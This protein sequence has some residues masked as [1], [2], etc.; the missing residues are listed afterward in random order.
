MQ[1]RFAAFVRPLR[2][3][4]LCVCFKRR[5]KK[6]SAFYV[7][8]RKHVVS[9]QGSSG[10][11]TPHFAIPRQTREVHDFLLVSRPEPDLKATSDLEPNIMLDLI[12]VLT[13]TLS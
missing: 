10:M 7:P 1:S 4:A 5:E 8:R 12:L 9:D 13:A 6:S 11:S 3:A 2:R